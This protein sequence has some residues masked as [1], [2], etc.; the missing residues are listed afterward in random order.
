MGV[1]PKN[2]GLVYIKIH[3]PNAVIQ[4][5]GDHYSFRKYFK[6]NHLELSKDA[7]P[8]EKDIIKC[9][10]RNYPGPGAYSTIDRIYIV[11]KFLR[12]MPFGD[13]E[14]YRGIE[15]LIERGIFREVYPLHDG[16]FYIMD[17]DYT[18]INGRQALHENWVGSENIIRRQPVN[19]IREYLGERMGF[20][21][22]FFEF[23]NLG[24]VAALVGGILVFLLGHY[25]KSQAII[26]ASACTNNTYKFPHWFTE[27]VWLTYRL[28]Y[29]HRHWW[30]RPTSVHPLQNMTYECRHYW[31]KVAAKGQCPYNYQMS[32]VTV[33]STRWFG[34][35]GGR[36]WW[37]IFNWFIPIAYYYQYQWTSTYSRAEWRIGRRSNYKITTYYDLPV[38]PKCKDF[39]VCPFINM[40]VY[41][42]ETKMKTAI[43]NPYGILALG[44][45]VLWAIL[46]SRYWQRKEYYLYWM[47]EC[48]PDDMDITFSSVYEHVHAVVAQQARDMRTMKFVLNK[49]AHILCGF[50]S[51]VQKC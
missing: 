13:A 19:T 27:T 12:F 8:D 21:F 40:T 16:P 1:A 7:V 10:R 24:L 20:L 35:V 45:I 48:R 38:C 6:N 22:A 50:A 43:D 29:S 42:L 18:S 9:I 3:A 23:Y 25:S 37:T 31:F 17:Q 36:G 49:R 46:F 32:M 2:S 4:Q 30:S 15:R 44:F 14:N 51:S 26:N 11:Y 39:Q 41:C 5:L 47:W 34:G 33:E 28:T